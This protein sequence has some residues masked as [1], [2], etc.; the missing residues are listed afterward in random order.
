MDSPESSFDFFK[1]RL[2][3]LDPVAFIEKYLRL[4]G[5]PFRIHGNGYRPFAD[6]Y[7]YIGIKSLEPTAKPVLICKG[8]QVGMS[9]AAAALEMYFM[10]SGL[11]GGEGKPP[12]RV[13]HAFPQKEH[14]EKFSKEKLNPMIGFSAAINQVDAD[15]GKGSKSYMQSLL[16]MGDTNNSLH[17]KQ[18]SNGNFLR[19]DSTGLTGDRLRGGSAD[20]IMYDEVQDISGEAIGTTVEMLKQAKY[21]RSPGGVQVYFG[22]PKR[23]GSDFWKMWMISSQQ[24]YHLGCGKCKQLFPFYTPE[25][26]EWEKIWLRE[27]IVKCPHCG[28]EQDKNAAAERGKW[29]A[30]RDLNDPDVRFVGFHINQC[31]MPNIKRED[32]ELEKPGIHPT[33]TERKFQNEVMGEFYQGDASPITTEEIIAKCGDRERGMRA[34]IK[35][36]DEQLVLLGID[37]GARNDREQLANPDRA[38]QGQSYTTAVVMSV[39]GPNLFSIDLAIKFPKNDPEAKKGLID[40]IMRQYSVNLAVADIGFSNDFSYTMHTIYGDKYLVSR[41][42]GKITDKVKLNEHAYP[43]EIQ[44][45]HDHYISEIYELL[46]KGQFKFPLKDYDRI[47][48]LIEHCANMEMKAS[49]PKY[50]GEPQIHY[51]KSG[52]N[53]GL[54][55]I[56]NAY[57]GYKYFITK[58]FTIHNPHLMNQT[59][60][61]KEKIPAIVARISKKF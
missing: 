60:G 21:G 42:A 12:I 6:I 4:E 29:V 58:G 37:Y 40:T 5:K 33:N 20:V 7:R 47:A 16:E 48:W 26:N 1:N 10:G 35:Q 15:R 2:L 8:R 57:L 9:V 54:M 17:F 11:F 32:I 61:K 23:K 52:P 41:S 13:I 22:T 34:R 51:I 27:F 36:N 3:C 46:K 59:P 38:R 39:K 14:A 45:E 19:I 18:F 28:H 55:S 24:Y 30:T 53:D 49:V 56:I 44:F 43:K 50:G 25:S 31:Y